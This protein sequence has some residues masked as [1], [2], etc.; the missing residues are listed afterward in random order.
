MLPLIIAAHTWLSQAH[1]ALLLQR[2]QLNLAVAAAERAWHLS[3]DQ[4]E[5]SPEAHASDD[6]DPNP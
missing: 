4:S 3:L 6:E 5:S 1:Q 2:V